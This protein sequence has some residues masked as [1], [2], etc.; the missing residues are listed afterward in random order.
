MSPETRA[1][2]R[3]AP[4]SPGF[5]LAALGESPHSAGMANRNVFAIAGIAIFLMVGAVVAIGVVASIFMVLYGIVVL[6]FHSAFGIELP[7]LI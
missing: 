1:P 3:P 2:R 6:I 7:H 5:V 4:S